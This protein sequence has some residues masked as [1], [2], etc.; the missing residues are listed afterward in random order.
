[1]FEEYLQDAYEFFIAAKK[2]AEAEDERVARR[3]YRAAVFYTLGA[4]E[5]FVNYIAD[6]FAK[7]ESIPSHEIAFLNDKSFHFST[8]KFRLIERTE[9]H[10][11][12]DKLKFLIRKFVPGF[13]FNSTSWCR[14]MEFKDF[15]DSLLHPRQGEDETSTA[16]YERKLRTGM[17]GTIEIMNR[18]SR[19]I[20][21]KPLRK[22]ILDLIP[23]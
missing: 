13:K 6:S 1:M 4:I 10:R 21:K 20:F 3:F 9:Y 16:E 8:D 15:R 2:A 23:E 11:L 19:G 22:K 12:E 14:T 5:A 17:A 18:V 7:A